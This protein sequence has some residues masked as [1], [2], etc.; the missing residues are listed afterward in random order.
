LG[1]RSPGPDDGNEPQNRHDLPLCDRRS[2]FPVFPCRPGEAILEE[3]LD[4]SSQTSLFS[5]RSPRGFVMVRFVNFRLGLA[6][7]LMVALAASVFAQAQTPGRAEAEASQSVLDAEAEGLVDVR[8]IANDARS[9]QVL[10]TNR[11]NRP[12]TIRLP[13]AFAGAPVLAQVAG[14]GQAGAG[15]GAGGI[16]GSPQNVGGGGVQNAGMGI[17]GGAGGNPFCWVA[18][19]VYGVHDPRWLAFRN[20][21]A[22]Q[23]PDILRDTYAEYGEAFSGWLHERPVAKA[24]VRLAMDQVVA[25]TSSHAHGGH[26]RVNPIIDSAS[27]PFTVPAGKT[28]AVRAP[29]VCLDYGRREPTPRM[30]YRLVAIETVS[31]DPRLAV[32]LGGL[33]TG[34][35]PQK[36]AQ[37]AA[38]HLSSGRTWDQLA[39]EVIKRAGGDPDVPF[40]SPAELA[41][42]QRAVAIA[43]KIVGDQPSAAADSGAVSSDSQQ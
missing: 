41:A 14:Q 23:A 43:T 17:G 7:T 29:T 31:Q 35:V 25:N 10:V 38:W 1:A 26:L 9:A 2:E 4:G 19:E 6:A 16:G 20:W 27:A 3:V 36:V 5:I 42:A 30:P 39:A 33:S 12:L 28:V 24:V 34:H 37:A 8:F 18:R 22:W 11:S 40:F 32:I 21:M 13:S 15:F